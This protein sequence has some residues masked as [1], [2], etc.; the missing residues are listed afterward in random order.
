MAAQRSTKVK[1]G[2][3]TAPAKVATEPVTADVRACRIQ[4]IR[5]TLNA[6]FDAARSTQ[7]IEED[8]GRM[9]AV[10]KA[11]MV[12]YL[13]IATICGDWCGNESG[14]VTQRDVQLYNYWLQ[15]SG[16]GD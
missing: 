5:D 12:P 7:V 2:A 15:A 10:A 14:S 13:F 6:V 9:E 11:L 4:T 3:E 16:S 8:R 1:P